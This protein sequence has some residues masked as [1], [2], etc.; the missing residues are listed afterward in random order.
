MGMVPVVSQSDER[1]G[2]SALDRSRGR[3]NPGEDS[4]HAWQKSSC[5]PLLPRNVLWP[6]CPR[7]LSGR[8]KANFFRSRA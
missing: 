1:L 5:V 6:G 8:D 3:E 7:D 2:T 4:Y